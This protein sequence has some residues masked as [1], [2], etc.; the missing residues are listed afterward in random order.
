MA[1]PAVVLAPAET[2]SADVAAPTSK[3]MIHP[4]ADRLLKQTSDTL[5]AAK[6]FSF[7]VEIWDDQVVGDGHKVSTTKTR[8]CR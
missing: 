6:Q 7:K 8:R 5:V 2:A 1:A 3:P 4:E